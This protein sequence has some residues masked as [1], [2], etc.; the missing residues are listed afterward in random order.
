[1]LDKAEGKTTREALLNNYDTIK[2]QKSIAVYGTRLLDSDRVKE[3]FVKVMEVAG[4]TDEK[5]A[6]RID[7][8]LDA[9]RIQT[10]PTEQDK[11]LPDYNARHKYITTYLQVKGLQDNATNTINQNILMNRPCLQMP[12]DK[13]KEEAKKLLLEDTTSGC[14]SSEKEVASD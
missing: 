5:V 3:A 1:M 6:T 14:V 8:G 13:L 12:F 9:I 10:S 11:L 7:E 4:A 2:T